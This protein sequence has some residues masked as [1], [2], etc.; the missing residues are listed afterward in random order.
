MVFRRKKSADRVY[1]Q[2]V[3]NERVAGRVRQRVIAT[4]GRRDELAA[5]GARFCEHAVPVSALAADAEG[6]RLHCRRIGPPLVFGRLWEETGCGGVIEALLAD[7][8]HGRGFAFAVERVVFTAVLH[9]LLVS[10]S[11]RACEKW[12]ADDAIPGTADL[13]QHHFYRAMAWPGE[14]IAP[15]GDG[16]LAPRCVKDLIEERLFQRR[17]DPFS[18]LSVVFMD[19]TTLSFEGAGGEAQLFVKE[20]RVDGARTIVCRNQA[21]AELPTARPSSPGWRNNSRRATR[22][23][24]ATPPTG[25]TCAPPSRTPSRSTPASSP[26][27]PATTASSHSAATPP[28]PRCRR[29]YAPAI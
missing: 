28:S 6:P 17:R 27:R 15:A 18:E 16:G 9:R 29:C 10:G 25:V 24:S 14:E 8:L 19:T 7:L 21:E 13:Q 20:V 11:D 1:V 22:R 26:L 3:E 5:T 23:R 12:M 4:L 2:I